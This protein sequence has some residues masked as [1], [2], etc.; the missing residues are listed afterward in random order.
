MNNHILTSLREYNIVDTKLALELEATLTTPHVDYPESPAAR[1]AKSRGLTSIGFGY[2]VN[3]QGEVVGRI[4][5]GEFSDLSK[6]KHSP[7]EDQELRQKSLDRMHL[8]N[9]RNKQRS[10]SLRGTGYDLV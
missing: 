2:Y 4:V 9:A 6:V 7:E 1:L 8:T 10:S 3:D 5:K